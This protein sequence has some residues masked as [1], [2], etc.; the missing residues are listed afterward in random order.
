MEPEQVAQAIRPEDQ[1]YPRTAAVT[2]ENTHNRHGGIAWPLRAL[3]AA[4]QQARDSG[5]AVHIDGAR[6]FNAAIAVRA[7]VKDLAAPR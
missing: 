3:Q 4:S 1:H 2:F 6:I 5:I 7:D